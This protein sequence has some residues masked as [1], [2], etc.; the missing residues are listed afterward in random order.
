[1]PALT[2]AQTRPATAPTVLDARLTT[3]AESDPNSLQQ[4]QANREKY[5]QSRERQVKKRELEV[6]FALQQTTSQK[7]TITSLQNK[8]K[9]LE[10]NNRNL[11]LQAATGHQAPA[12]TQAHIM[13]TQNNPQ[14]QL[15]QAMSQLRD[16]V[17][18]L[19]MKQKVDTLERSL[20]SAGQPPPV[21]HAA[22]PQYQMPHVMTAPPVPTCQMPHV[23]TAPP[24]PTYQMPHAMTA[25]PAPTYI[26]CPTR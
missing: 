10:L 26:R 17:L 23:M 21:S 18:R 24:V 1:M 5:L 4:Q 6:N 14:T 16:Q 20:A 9:D 2:K 8:I 19:E 15:H 25:P 11:K 22:G 13:E 12:A 3:A 7:V